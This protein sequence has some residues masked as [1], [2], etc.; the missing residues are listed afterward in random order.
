MHKSKKSDTLSLSTTLIILV[1]VVCGGVN[2]AFGA[3]GVLSDM[4]NYHE[5][6]GLDPI[7]SNYPNLGVSPK[8][9]L[10]GQFKVVLIESNAPGNVYHEGE[11][12]RFTFQ[13]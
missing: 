10:Q 12:P 1:A 6:F 4:H 2:V 3:W 9:K 8:W 13:I 11:E 7:Q 5:C